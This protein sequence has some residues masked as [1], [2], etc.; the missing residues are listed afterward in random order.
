MMKGTN[1]IPSKLKADEKISPS[2]KLIYLEINFCCRKF[3]EC[4]FSN[5]DF[6]EMLG[7]SKN[8]ILSSIKTLAEK[9]WINIDYSR[10]LEGQKSRVIT[11]T[12]GSKIE[13]GGSAKIELG[14]VQNLNQGS[15]KFEPPLISNTIKYTIRNKENI[16]ENNKERTDV[17]VFGND[18]SLSTDF[19]EMETR[20]LF[21]LFW[22]LFPDVK[23]DLNENQALELFSKLDL[24]SD[25]EEL[26]SFIENYIN[27]DKIRYIP[28]VKALLGESKF[29]RKNIRLNAD[30]NPENII[31]PATLQEMDSLLADLKI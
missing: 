26:M 17:V 27:E 19:T 10:K 15:A 30:F 18:S 3:K 21:E 7:M 23:K 25:F 14:V 5:N 20:K 8:T 1:L 2:A 28:K 16:K 22:N 24:K 12:S 4:T 13:L 29:K 11:I 31:H 9:G 6:Q